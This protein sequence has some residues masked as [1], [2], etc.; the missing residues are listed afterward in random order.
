MEKIL[1]IDDNEDQLK[2]IKKA[3]ER[4]DPKIKVYTVRTAE[5]A[6]DILDRE[7]V[8]AIFVDYVLKDTNGIK[9]IK[10]ISHQGLKVPTILITGRGDERT[11]VEAMKA[12]AYDYVVKD[13]G[14]FNILPHVFK[15]AAER[16]HAEREVERVQQKM[17]EFSEKLLLINSIIKELN[18]NLDLSYTASSFLA[19]AIKLMNADGGIISIFEGSKKKVLQSKGITINEDFVKNIMSNINTVKVINRLDNTYE[20]LQEFYYEGIKSLILSPLKLWDEEEGI[21]ILFN[22][23]NGGFSETDLRSFD[24]LFDSGCASLRNSLLFQLISKSQRFW[25]ETFDSISDIIFILDNNHNIVKCNK[26]FANILNIDPPKVIGR[27]IKDLLEAHPI[28][29]C[30]KQYIE[31]GSEHTKELSNREYVCLISSFSSVMPD[32]ESVK[33]Y[34]IKDITELRRLKEQLYHADKL[35][36]IG[37][38]VSGVAHEINNPLTGILGYTELLK[39]KVSDPKITRELDKIYTAAE[40]CK[41]IVE[42]LL[43]FSRQKPPEKT[44]VDI[45]DLIESAIELRIYWLRSN[46]IDVIREFSDLPAI[47]IDPQQLQQVFMNLLVNA[48]HAVIVTDKKEKWIKIKTFKKEDEDK[49]CIVVQ[50]NGIGIPEDHLGKIFDPFFTTKPVGKGSGLGLSIS[51]GIIKEHNGEIW[52]ESTPGE[53]TT[54]YI[55]LPIK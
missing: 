51:H 55:E 33:I 37:Q 24:L 3:F 16:F 48:E 14:Y 34:I 12:G 32:G 21:L 29:N 27:N 35:A 40:R 54:F 42:N 47:Y 22:K 10:E 6:F 46:N 52:A 19:G 28:L 8:Q 43:T 45:N 30:C 17:L 7:E 4:Y 38:L 11:A 2:L 23:S 39:M 53:G 5:E 50:D 31:E 15:K 18:E 26:T 36:S 13:I 49:I 1:V 44:Y 20:H 41:R 9:F 25:Q